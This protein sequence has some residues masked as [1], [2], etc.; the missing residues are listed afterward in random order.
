MSPDISFVIVNWNTRDLVI[1]CVRSIIE[2]VRDC[3]HEIFVV[4][5]GSGDGSVEA[6]RGEFGDRIHVIA[7]RDNFGFARANNQALARAR[8]R[9]VALVNSDALLHPNTM[10]TLVDFLEAHP[11]AAM[12]GPRMLGQ[13]GREQNSFDNFPSLLTELG[14]KSLLRLLRPGRYAGKSGRCEQ[15]FE[16]DSLIGACI[17]VRA[18]AMQQV[19]LLDEGYFFFLEETDW[20]L[21]MRRHGWSMYHV[22]AASIIHLQGQSKKRRPV[23]SWIEYYRSMYRYFKKNHS[24]A[25]YAA[26]RIFRVVKLCV[27]LLLNCC[28]LVLTIGRNRRFREKTRVYAGILW[29]HIRLCPR[30]VGLHAGNVHDR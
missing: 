28:G 8:G 25:A 20:C 10:A 7:N 5:N 13:D 12:A 22:P 3:D 24:I 29:W 17:L 9:Y 15:P 6:L 14:N 26:L 21:R 18:E 16:V 30:G 27:D 4:D 11:G 23:M 1:A 2:T 19:G